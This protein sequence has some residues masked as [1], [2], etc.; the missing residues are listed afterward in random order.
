MKVKD[1]CI[2]AACDCHVGRSAKLLWLRDLW[3]VYCIYIECPEL[4]SIE[5][6]MQARHLGFR[7][8]RSCL[9]IG[10]PR[11]L[12]RTYLFILTSVLTRFFGIACVT[13]TTS[14]YVPILIPEWWSIQNSIHTNRLDGV[15]IS[16][17]AS[18]CNTVV[19]A[20]MQHITETQFIG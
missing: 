20:N 18:N 2:A 9:F 19:L 8:H 15:I 7:H 16:A 10:G 13:F 6:K 12:Y 3:Q 4:I 11:S 17:Y 5:W 14:G 1:H